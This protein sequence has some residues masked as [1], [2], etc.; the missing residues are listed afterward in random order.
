MGSSGSFAAQVGVGACKLEAL[1]GIRRGFAAP[2]ASSHASLERCL[3]LRYRE[4]LA[5]ADHGWETR[6]TIRFKQVVTLFQSDQWRECLVQEALEVKMEPGVLNEDNAMKLSSAS[7]P[8][9]SLIGH[10][11]EK[12]FAEK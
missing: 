3:Q 8:V 10:K 9:L 7:L 1:G 2:Q 4:K 12:D 11:R 6:H 5:L